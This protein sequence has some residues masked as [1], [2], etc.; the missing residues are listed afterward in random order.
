MH[1]LVLTAPSTLEV[2]EAPSI[3]LTAGQVRLRVD[4]AGICG[5][6][7]HGYSGLNDRRPVG[8]V[9][10]HETAGTV[11]E[12]AKGS[13]LSLG[14][15]VA[16]NPLISCRV[17]TYCRTGFDNLCSDR[18]LYGCS[19]DA[20]GGLATEMV[21]EE[22]NAVPVPDDLDI[23][24]IT[25]IEPLSIGTHAVRIAT[26]PPKSSLLVIGGG[27]IG[28]AAALAARDVSTNLTISEPSEHRRHIA[29][30]LGF[31][32]RTPVEATSGTEYDAV[33]ECV[34]YSATTAQAVRSVKP[35]GAVV[36]LGFADEELMVPA[37][38]VVIEEKRLIGSSAYTRDD[39]D[40]T[41][42]WVSRN[43]SGLKQLVG[44]RV[45]LEGTPR[46]F[47]QYA[48]GE[49]S[50]MKTIY[51]PSPRQSSLSSSPREAGPED[52]S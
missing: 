1:Q 48:D 6:D 29:Q 40:A 7:I 18:R 12:V 38:G 31:D 46:V 25:L 4:G 26:L 44:A 16:V 17:C 45:S 9:M 42:S 10:G 20:P 13:R 11:V 24:V 37:V 50:V 8:V 36:C 3:A 21:I 23:D 27:P 52:A 47:R 43:A 49:S 33:I 14:Q 34:G 30:Q 2:R 28:I 35:G 51:T 5:S 41:A 19:V 22:T 39:F 32:A 15:R